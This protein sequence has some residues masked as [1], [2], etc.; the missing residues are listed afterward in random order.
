[1]SPE[2]NIIR[3]VK[4]YGKNIDDGNIVN[5][6][7]F[8]KNY[9]IIEK[10]KNKHVLKKFISRYYYQKN[11]KLNGKFIKSMSFED[12]IIELLPLHMEEEAELN[13][14][15]YVMRK[16]KLKEILLASIGINKSA[17]HG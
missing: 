8:F 2:Y 5:I 16:G 10:G 3:A 4:L 12:Y 9:T 6:M 1:M 11:K 17:I 13:F 15:K 14:Q 7:T